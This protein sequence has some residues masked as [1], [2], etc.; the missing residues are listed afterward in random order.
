MLGYSVNEQ[1]G[2]LA[3]LL[4]AKGKILYTKNADRH[5]DP[6]KI[7]SKKVAHGQKGSIALRW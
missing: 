3:V 7:M 5:E 6:L 4:E 2:N 1:L